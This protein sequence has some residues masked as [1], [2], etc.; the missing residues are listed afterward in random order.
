MIEPEDFV[1]YNP[2][3]LKCRMNATATFFDNV[4]STK[5]NPLKSM[6]SETYS[7][8]ILEKL[9]QLASL[10]DKET[11]IAVGKNSSKKEAETYARNSIRQGLSYGYKFTS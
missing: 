8:A 2:I 10:N 1:K 9:C 3:Y 4:S 7:L 11:A 5:F 6:H